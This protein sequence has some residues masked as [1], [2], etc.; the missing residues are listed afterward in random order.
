MKKENTGS[1]PY[2]WFPQMRPCSVL[3]DTPPPQIGNFN[4]NGNASTEPAF[5]VLETVDRVVSP[6]SSKTVRDRELG[7]VDDSDKRFQIE[8][9]GTF[10]ST[11]RPN[12]GVSDRGR[13][14]SQGE[15]IGPG[16]DR[17]S[18]YRLG[19]SPSGETKSPRRQ[20]RRTRQDRPAQEIALASWGG[21]P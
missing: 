7:D 10:L 21:Q 16:R 9:G 1:Y 4:G 13:T 12:W 19:I 6:K 14:G 20:I 3:G 2:C 8:A 18:R 15:D 17:P 5:V 11:P